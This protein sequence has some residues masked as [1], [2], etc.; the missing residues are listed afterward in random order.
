ME[1]T[2][3][4][5]HPSYCSTLGEKDQI[6]ALWGEICI[7]VIHFPMLYFIKWLLT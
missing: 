2:R 7:M 4:L 3:A 1:F 6:F 5:G